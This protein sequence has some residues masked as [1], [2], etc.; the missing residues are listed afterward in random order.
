[1]TIKDFLLS[2]LCLFIILQLQAQAIS[3]FSPLEPAKNH[4]A[5]LQTLNGAPNPA[6]AWMDTILYPPSEYNRYTMLFTLGQPAYL[7]KDQ[8]D[9]IAG[10][11][12]FPANSSEQTRA[13]LD[14]LMELQANRTEEQ[15]KRVLDIASI[16]Y[17]PDVHNVPSHPNHQENLEEL[18]FEIHEVMGK[19]HTHDQYPATSKLLRGIMMD[20]RMMEFVVKYRLFRARPYQLELKLEPL[21]K[22]GSPSFASG[23][24][25]WAYCQA[26]TLAELLPEKKQAFLDLAYEIA[27]SR[28]LMGVHYPSDEEVARQIAHR[29]I[30]LM[31]HSKSFQDDFAAAKKEWK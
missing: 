12:E 31:W 16:G 7:T 2:T 9:F 17:W 4:Y 28:E 27:F 15:T 21:R 29:M 20:M 5:E 30:W 25:L 10:E 11:V 22:I 8:I 24:T 3:N 26:F 18:F 14:F 6:M 23:H 1:M 19:E 13:E